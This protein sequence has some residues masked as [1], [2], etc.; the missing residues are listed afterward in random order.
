MDEREHRSQPTPAA[1]T[2]AL[3][4][5]EPEHP[6]L[7]KNRGPALAF[8][9]LAIIVVVGLVLAVFSIGSLVGG[10]SFGHRPIGP[11]AL[12]LRMGVV[13]VGTALAALWLNVWWIG[14]LLFLAGVGIAPALAVM[15][16]IVSSSVLVRS[17]S[18]MK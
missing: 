6:K 17:V 4:T 1:P 11:W 13:F 9:I 16:A 2:T 18:A 14:A 5:V 7:V 15:F 12:A 8:L 10:L 3:P